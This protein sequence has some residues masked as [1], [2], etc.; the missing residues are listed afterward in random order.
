MARKKPVHRRRASPDP[1]GDRALFE[2][3]IE[4]LGPVPPD[5]SG[6]TDQ[7]RTAEAGRRARFTKRVA[8]GDVE[9][10]AVLDLHGLDR[11]AATDR[12]RRFLSSAHSEVKVILVVHG[13]G[14]GVLE[15]ATVA[16]LD[17]HPRV[18][19]HVPAP[20]AFGGAGAR[21]VRLR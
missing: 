16:E 3:A 9:P 1:S 6:E 14:L 15:Q 4:R 7:E 19:E 18:A 21:L 12:L 2:E 11:A 13:R 20:P 17:R 10:E 5:K 8:R